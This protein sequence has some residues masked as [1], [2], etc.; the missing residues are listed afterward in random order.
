MKL[1]IETVPCP[2]EMH[3]NIGKS[4]NRPENIQ[5]FVQKRAGDPAIKVS[6]RFVLEIQ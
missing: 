6:L 5:R 4:Q 3:H 2:P 1:G